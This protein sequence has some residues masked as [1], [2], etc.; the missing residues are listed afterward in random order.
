MANC[1]KKLYTN[2]TEPCDNPL[3]QGMQPI[4]WIGNFAELDKAETVKTK[5]KI[6]SLALKEGAKLYR[7]YQSGKE[8]FNGSTKEMVVGAFRN[9]WNKNF[10][11]I[12][13]DSGADVSENIIDNF[14][15]G[16]FFSILENNFQG[17]NGDNAFEMVG[18]EQGLTATAIS[19][20]KDSDDTGGG[21]LCEMQ[22]AL[23]PSSGVFVMYDSVSTTRQ[24]L[25]ALTAN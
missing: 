11:F 13:L 16:R 19:Q 25:E 4:G 14:A 21:W 6:T 23:A 17:K 10:R 15:N 5:N 22:E 9:N 12:V 2:I 20:D 7:I 24:A 8:P 1:D 18:Y 3:I